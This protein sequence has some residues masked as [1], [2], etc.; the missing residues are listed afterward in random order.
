[1]LDLFLSRW[2]GGWGLLGWGGSLG[3]LLDWLGEAKLLLQ[4]IALSDDS[5]WVELEESA[6]V[7]QRVSLE[8]TTLTIVRLL[9]EN[10]LNLIGGE[11]TA[12]IAVGH[13]WLW[14]AEVVLGGRLLLVG[15]VDV[16]ELLEGRL[17]PD[18]EA[19]Q[20]TTWSDLQQVQALNVEESDAW[21]VTES[22]SKTLVL[23]VDDGWATLHDATTVT[24]LTLT[25]T[26][27]LGGV[28]LL[29]ILPG[30]DLLEDAHGLLGLLDLLDLVAEN[31]RDL[32]SLFDLVAL[33]QDEAWNARGSDGAHESDQRHDQHNNYLTHV[34]VTPLVRKNR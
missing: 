17:G 16:V 28:H 22:T 23:L 8:H 2:L 4:G 3:D 12:Q 26:E 29:D 15:A 6:V 5:V 31:E 24:H 27:S 33:G 18:A 32:W 19:T 11:E 14:Q 10:T 1:V 9:L 7:L 20:V 13:L 21:D 25:G 34:N 30:V